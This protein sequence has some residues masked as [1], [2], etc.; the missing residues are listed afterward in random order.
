MILFVTGKKRLSS[1]K[2]KVVRD[3]KEWWTFLFFKHISNSQKLIAFM[4]AQ[5]YRKYLFYLICQ[6]IWH[7]LGFHPQSVMLVTTLRQTSLWR[8]FTYSLSVGHHWCRFL[9]GKCIKK[10]VL[11]VFVQFNS[12]HCVND[13]FLNKITQ[14][15]FRYVKSLR[16]LLYKTKTYYM[17]LY[18]CNNVLKLSIFSH[19]AT[20][21]NYYA[22]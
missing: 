18:I 2:M 12:R 6:S 20:W 4:L 3:L 16:S 10:M 7:R 17:F 9:Y 8:Y 21:N 13:E 22:N 1:E 11:V 14:L 5:E 19:Q 15:I